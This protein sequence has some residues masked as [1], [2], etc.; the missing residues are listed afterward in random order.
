MLIMPPGVL[1]ILGVLTPL[2]V[3]PCKQML[4]MHHV[5]IY[6][7]LLTSPCRYNEKVDVWSVGCVLGDKAPNSHIAPFLSTQASDSI[8]SSLC[9]CIQRVIL[10]SF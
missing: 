9:T 1:E 7:R 10:I 4:M 5:S 3:R 2:R 8:T 6:K